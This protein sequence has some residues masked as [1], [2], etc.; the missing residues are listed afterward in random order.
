M[1]QIKRAVKKKTAPSIQRRLF[2]DCIDCLY[3]YDL[4]ED[5]PSHWPWR[6]QAAIEN[7]RTRIM[8]RGSRIVMHRKHRS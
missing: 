6:V 1:A 3:E 5:L 8:Q 2:D 4:G 7:A